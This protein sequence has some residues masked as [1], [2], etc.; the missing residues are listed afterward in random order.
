MSRPPMDQEDE[1][2]DDEEAD[3]KIGQRKKMNQEL[4]HVLP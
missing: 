4:Q 3:R 2:S 1:S